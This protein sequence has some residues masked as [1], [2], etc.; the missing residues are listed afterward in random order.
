[1]RGPELR[2][3]GERIAAVLHVP[4]KA[5]D[6]T[7]GELAILIGELC[8]TPQE[9]ERLTAHLTAQSWGRFDLAEVR[10]R[11]EI[12]TG[13]E[14]AKPRDWIAELVTR[15]C[16]LPAQDIKGLVSAVDI[17]GELYKAVAEADSE[18]HATRA[19]DSMA[20]LP[21][22]GGTRWRPTPED[23]RAAIADTPKQ[24][25]PPIYPAN[26]HCKK[27]HGEGVLFKEKAYKHPITGLWYSGSRDCPCRKKPPRRA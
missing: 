25:P 18:D 4:R 26:P 8:D 16:I 14:V 3:Y 12:L 2:E 11:A 13:R 19:I 6:T 7:T 23:V 9:A 24:P 27:C 17:R 10:S 21:T 20:A 15:L 22:E 1:M 5:L